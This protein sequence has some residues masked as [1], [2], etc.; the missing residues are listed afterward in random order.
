MPLLQRRLM[1]NGPGCDGACGAREPVPPIVVLTTLSQVF[2]LL[3][4]RRATFGLGLTA[5]ISRLP[6]GENEEALELRFGRLA[7][8]VLA[9]H[10]IELD[11]PTG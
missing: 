3:R 5:G 7:S 6:T 11:R 9:Q 1:A 10:G 2:Q 8:W 4:R